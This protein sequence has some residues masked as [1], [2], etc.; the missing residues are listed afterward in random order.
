M[1]KSFISRLKAAG[2]H[3]VMSFLAAAL[4]AV[5]V[6]Q[7]WFPADY[8]HVAGGQELFLLLAT[9]DLILGP[10]LTFMVFNTQKGRLH[11]QRDLAVIV[12]IQLSALLYGLTT[13]FQARPIALVFEKDRFKV[14]TAVQVHLP[15]LEKAPS[16]FQRLPLSG[17]WLL[18]SREPN[19]AERNEALFMALDG[20][21]RAQRP[22]FWQP[23]NESVARVLSRARPLAQLLKQY[24]DRRDEINSLLAPHHLSAADAVFLPLIA[25]Q[26]DWVAILDARGTPVHF[27]QADG[28]F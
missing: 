25:R 18:G 2:I 28:F 17:P 10:L 21:D 15:E 5:L 3:L 20:I 6:F 12:L 8:R 1:R 19:D 7:V 23:Y 14:I 11:L 13:V 26:G 4:A 16:A 22:I 27:L 9:V 24:P